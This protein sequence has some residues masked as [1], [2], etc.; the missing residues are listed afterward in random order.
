MDQIH[1]LYFKTA[2]P[3]SHIQH[4]S[5]VLQSVLYVLCFIYIFLM[6]INFCVSSFYLLFLFQLQLWFNLWSFFS[7]NIKMYFFLFFYLNNTILGHSGVRHVQVRTCID[8][9]KSFCFTEGDNFWLVT[10]L[11][12]ID[13]FCVFYMLLCIKVRALLTIFRHKWSTRNWSYAWCMNVNICYKV[14]HN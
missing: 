1:L 2:H 13:L 9:F 14:V 3:D 8:L 4:R 10:V 11:R 12:L 6:I 7:D 5:I